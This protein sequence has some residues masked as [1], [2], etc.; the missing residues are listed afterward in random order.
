MHIY[1]HI[2]ISTNYLTHDAY[3]HI[4]THLFRTSHLTSLPPPP[5]QSFWQLLTTSSITPLH[6]LY[7][8]ICMR[9]YVC[10]NLHEQVSPQHACNNSHTKHTHAHTHSQNTHTH[11][12]T[13]TYKHIPTHT[14][15]HTHNMAYVCICMYEQR[16]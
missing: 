14:H 4:Y 5:G 7:M 3:I 13:I 8:C 15:T 12:H 1:T 6:P 2:H 9:E 11:I 10:M 16:I